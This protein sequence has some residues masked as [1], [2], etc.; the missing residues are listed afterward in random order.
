M[1]H[2][3]TIKTIARVQ[4]GRKILRQRTYSYAIN[5][6]KQKGEQKSAVPQAKL[7]LPEVVRGITR[8]GG[9]KN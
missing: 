9:N 4:V 1:V 2:P 5:G 8:P 7:H 3:E 6:Q